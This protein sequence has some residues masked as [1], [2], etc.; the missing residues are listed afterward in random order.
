[1]SFV[2]HTSVLLSCTCTGHNRKT[3]QHVT[4]IMCFLP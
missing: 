4:R 1:M 3:K 2:H